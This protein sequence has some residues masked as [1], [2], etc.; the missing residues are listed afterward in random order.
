MASCALNS[1]K[2]KIISTGK[3]RNDLKVNKFDVKFVEDLSKRLTAQ[4]SSKYNLRA[5][6][7]FEVKEILGFFSN[8]E[9]AAIHG[10]NIT[11]E[12]IFNS[13]ALEFLDK[14]EAYE[15]D[16]NADAY[17]AQRKKQERIDYQRDLRFFNFDRA[18]YEQ[19]QAELKDL[20]DIKLEC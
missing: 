6:P 15:R 5:Y 7:L 13:E 12:V 4:Y 10:K 8:Q 16:I 17:R 19:E 18:L 14:S 11:H 2:D 1:V 9:R 20:P 3:V